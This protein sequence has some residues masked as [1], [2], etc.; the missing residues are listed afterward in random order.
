MD[1]VDGHVQ[2]AVAAGARAATGGTRGEHCNYPATVLLDV[3]QDMRCMREET[4]GP[5]LPIMRVRDAEQ[6]IELANDSQYGLSASVWTKDREKAESIADR[7]HAGAVNHNDAMMNLLQFGAPH[8][9][10]RDSGVGVRFGGASGIRKYTHPQVLLTNRVEPKS[11]VHWYP[12]SKAKGA[13]TSRV[14]PLIGARD[15][16]RRLGRAPKG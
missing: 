5:T 12:Y 13:I 8:G 1:I 16:R 6:A 2:D 4:F 9:G 7:L 11:E 14:V 3:T 15:W 10:W